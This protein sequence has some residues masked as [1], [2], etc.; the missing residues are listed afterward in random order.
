MYFVCLQFNP[1]SAPRGGG[2]LLTVHGNNL[3]TAV[4][5]MQNGGVTVAGAPC[6]VLSEGYEPTTR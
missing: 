2:T 4:T 6:N 5:D 1:T 3:G